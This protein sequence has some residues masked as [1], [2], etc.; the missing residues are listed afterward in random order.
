MNKKV[1]LMICIFI[2]A[3]AL[4]SVCIAAEPTVTVSNAEAE[5][6]E[7]VT[8]N[9]TL[10]DNI[11]FGGIEL[12]ISFDKDELEL[13]KID[14]A[15]TITSFIITPCENANITGDIIFAYVGL[16]NVTGSGKIASLTFTVKENANGVKPLNITVVEDSSFVYDE[17][18]VMLDLSINAVSGAITVIRPVL[19]GDINGDGE[20]EVLD[21][22]LSLNALL[23]GNATENF[24][25]NGDGVFS[26]LDVLSVLK[27]A[28]A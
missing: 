27:F 28:A 5:P 10:E 14:T 21:V 16:S 1:F 18:N 9:V 24:D 13:T 4:T 17:N 25:A 2:F 22:L 12:C 15:D 23:N 26:L 11:A 19:P 7:S 3:F 8:V 6:L 20:V